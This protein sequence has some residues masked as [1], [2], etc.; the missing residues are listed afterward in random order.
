VPPTCSV[1]FVASAP[2]LNKT[3]ATA[4]APVFQ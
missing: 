1:T 2:L 3:T 4:G